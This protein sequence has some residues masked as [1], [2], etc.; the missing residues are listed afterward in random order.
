[1]D[2]RLFRFGFRIRSERRWVFRGGRRFRVSWIRKYR[3]VRVFVYWGFGIVVV[4]WVVVCSVFIV[5][6]VIDGEIDDRG[7]GGEG[8]I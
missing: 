5:F 2:F 1:M 7:G 4:C 8:G 6:F 3:W